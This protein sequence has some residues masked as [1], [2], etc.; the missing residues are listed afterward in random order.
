MKKFGNLL[1]IY[2][3]PIIF[4][5]AQTFSHYFDVEIGVVQNLK[6]NYGSSL[7]VKSRGENKGLKVI[8]LPEALA[9]IKQKKYQLVGCDGVF[10]GDKLVMDVCAQNATPHF[11]IMG[12]PNTEDEPSNNI[13]SFSWYSP[14]IQFRRRN[15]SEGYI[16]EIEWQHFYQNRPQGK[17]IFVFYPEMRDAKDH[18]WGS[19]NSLLLPYEKGKAKPRKGSISLIH[20]YEECNRWPYAVYKK[21]IEECKKTTPDFYI[22]NHTGLKQEYVYDLLCGANTLF[23]SKASDCP[24]I[25]LLEAMLLGAVPIVAK[26]FLTA[27][28]DQEVLIDGYSAIICDT[29]DDMVQACLE[30]YSV[31][32][33]P[34]LRV[35]MFEHI[36]MLTSFRRQQRGLERFFER[37]MN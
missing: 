25:S 9:N 27:S 7:E 2:Y 4:D 36:N 6:D 32:K 35:T 21:V 3:H 5:L 30:N 31:L 1:L 10:D 17:N 12:Y 20:R 14:Q 8:F 19:R 15:P 33:S 16:K 18:A 11:S 24:G 29:I 13:L 26:N 37:C 22:P 23:H 28:H 34:E